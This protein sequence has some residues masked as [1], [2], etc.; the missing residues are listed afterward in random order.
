MNHKPCPFCGGTSQTVKVVWKSW[1]FV[2]C[3]ICKA[4]GPVRKTQEEAI[5]AWKDRVQVVGTQLSVL[6]QE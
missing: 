2:A 3:D 5:Q 4:G 6:N 1:H